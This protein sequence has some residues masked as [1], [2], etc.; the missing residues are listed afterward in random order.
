MLSDSVR[1]AVDE[2]LT[3]PV[4]DVF[5]LYL[6]LSEDAPQKAQYPALALRDLART[7]QLDE[8]HVP[9][10]VA[11]LTC[12]TDRASVLHLAKALA[13]F[14]RRAQ[15]G[16]EPLLS[17]LDALEIDDDAAFWIFDAGL[18]A[19]GYLGGEA[20]Q[21]YVASLQMAHRSRVATDD[22]MYKGQMTLDERERRF[23]QTLSGV[24]ALLEQEDPGVWRDKKTSLKPRAL[25]ERGAHAA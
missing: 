14:G 15:D 17:H 23:D 25:G 13:A 10:L 5:Q 11:C 22:L 6:N 1:K 8:E 16:V 7:G 2:I 20:A 9:L 21:D 19:L 24:E 12:A 18:W 3:L 4:A